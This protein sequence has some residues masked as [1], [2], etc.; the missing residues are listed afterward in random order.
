[1]KRA[2]RRAPGIRVAAAFRSG[3]RSLP[4][5]LGKTSEGLGVAHGDV[6][7]GLAIQLHAGVTQPVHEL[8]VGQ[9]LTPGRGVDADDPQAPEIALA[10]APIAIGVLVGLEQ[11]LLGALVALARLAPVALGAGQRGPTLLTAVRGALD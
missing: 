2:P 9:A 10:V 4:G 6:R 1:M 11:R 7:Q 3:S 5:S 8:R